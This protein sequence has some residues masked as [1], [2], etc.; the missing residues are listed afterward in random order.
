[1]SDD[2]RQNAVYILKR[3][4]G[5]TRLRTDTRT[6]VR[7]RRL[8]RC[9]H[10]THRCNNKFIAHPHART[11]AVQ[12]WPSLSTRSMVPVGKYGSRMVKERTRYLNNG[13]G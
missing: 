8:V 4:S 12:I 10:N 6:H 11:L 9:A 3:A 5:P 1:M 13:G 7:M 2:T